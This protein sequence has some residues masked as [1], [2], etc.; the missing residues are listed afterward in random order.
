M[1]FTSKGVDISSPTKLL[2]EIQR[3][4]QMLAE[5]ERQQKQS[6]RGL[7]LIAVPSSKLYLEELRIEIR[8]RLEWTHDK[9]GEAIPMNGEGSP[10]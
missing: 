10:S 7:K 9:S 2:A 4:E 8:L 6:K 3:A 1:Q 5:A